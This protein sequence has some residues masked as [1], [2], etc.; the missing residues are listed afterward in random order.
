MHTGA[1]TDLE[2]QF[3]VMQ[4]LLRIFATL[5]FMALFDVA[6]LDPFDGCPALVSGLLQP[7]SYAV[8]SPIPELNA[9]LVTAAVEAMETVTLKPGLLPA[10]LCQAKIYAQEVVE[11]VQ[12]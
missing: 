1:I 9:T 5:Q 2:G 8:A 6:A 10:V 4:H 11:K 3:D 7:V 12:V